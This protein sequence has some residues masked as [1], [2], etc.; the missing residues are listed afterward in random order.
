MNTPVYE[1]DYLVDSHVESEQ[2]IRITDTVD[3]LTLYHY[4][5][6]FEDSDEFIK[7][8][9][10]VIKDSNDKIVCKTFGYTPEMTSDEADK[11]KTYIS[12]FSNCKFYVSHEGATIRLFFHNNRWYMSTHRK[13]DAFK[14]RW[15]NPNCKSF[16]DMFIDALEYEI[17]HGVLKDK[18]I[19]EH[20]NDI[21]YRFCE[22]LDVNKTYTFLVRNSNENR[23]VCDAPSHP[24]VLFIGS[25]DRST[26]LL[27]EGNDSGLNT[28]EL[29]EFNNVEQLLKYVDEVD[30]R[31]SQGIIVY[32]PNQTQFKIINPIYMKYFNTRGNEPSI[33][34]RYLQIRNNIDSVQMLYSLYPDFVSTFNTYEYILNFL[35]EKIY[36]AYLNRYIRHNYVSLPQNEYFVLQGCHNLYL[37][38][39]YN[40]KISIELVRKVLNNLSPTNLN[41]MIKP[42]LNQIKN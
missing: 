1:A 6:C 20:R 17:N 14:S 2:T 32:V 30:Y 4:T 23:I 33:K 8:T 37:Q 38:D 10:G 5:E 34:F 29:I 36:Y 12:S 39:K 13:I 35:V 42:Y 18:I 22:T 19:V 28:P 9:R 25:F 3:D 21:F 31:I 15:G 11:V 40:N 24:V 41:R 27:V 26:H 16:G 7:N